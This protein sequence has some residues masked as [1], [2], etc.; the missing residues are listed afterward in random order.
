MPRAAV[1][2]GIGSGRW[3]G[4]TTWDFDFFKVIFVLFGVVVI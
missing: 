3:T 2:R 1:T 4:L